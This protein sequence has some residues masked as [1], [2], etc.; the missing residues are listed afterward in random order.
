V[1]GLHGD[2]NCFCQLTTHGFAW[3]PYHT[4]KCDRESYRTDKVGLAKGARAWVRAAESLIVRSYRGLY[5]QG[6][7]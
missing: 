6:A 5:V 3:D 7:W 2:P 1:W 4:P